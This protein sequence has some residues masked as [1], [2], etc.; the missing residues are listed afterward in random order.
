MASSLNIKI[1]LHYFA[2]SPSLVSADSEMLY[3]WIRVIAF[4]GILGTSA[5]FLSMYTKKKRTRLNTKATGKIVIADTCSLG[6]RQFLMVA[7][8][9]EEKHLLGVSSSTI[10]HLAKIENISDQ[11]SESTVKSEEGF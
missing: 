7:Q 8:Y 1:M 9:G 4:I 11:D 6:N 10:N 2:T 5:Y 3:L